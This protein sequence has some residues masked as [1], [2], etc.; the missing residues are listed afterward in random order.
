MVIYDLKG[1]SSDG[2]RRGSIAK[3]IVIVSLVATLPT[4]YHLLALS[5]QRL[6]SMRPAQPECFQRDG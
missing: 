5:S 1:V 2:T 6:P 3:R 4:L